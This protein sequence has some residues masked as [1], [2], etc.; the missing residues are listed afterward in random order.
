[1]EFGDHYSASGTVHQLGIVAEKQSHWP[2]AVSNFIQVLVTCVELKYHL[3]QD[4]AMRGLARVWRASGDR[5]V[6]VETA[7]VLGIEPD[8]VQVIFT[9]LPED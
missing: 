4:L 6:V 3:E 2:E 9:E 5:H 7:S 1:M 8:E